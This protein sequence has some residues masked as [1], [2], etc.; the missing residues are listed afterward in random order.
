MARLDAEGF[1]Q[2]G[3][4]QGGKRASLRL[5]GLSSI[6][7]SRG[8]SSSS[9]SSPSSSCFSSSAVVKKGGKGA[10]QEGEE[11]GGG[12]VERRCSAHAIHYTN[13]I[14]NYPSN[15]RPLSSSLPSSM[16]W[17]ASLSAS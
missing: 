10:E 14:T 12:E 8:A 15:Q 13:T 3:M 7:I 11:E 1:K 4:K 16:H 6:G 2:R 5:R 17:Q 9:S